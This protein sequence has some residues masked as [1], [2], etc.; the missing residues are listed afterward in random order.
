M[1]NG[2]VVGI[3]GN[4]NFIEYAINHNHDRPFSEKRSFQVADVH[5][6]PYEDETFD[7]VFCGNVLQLVDDPA[8]PLQEFIR[9]TKIGGRVADKS[10]D[11]SALIFQPVD[12]ILLHRVLEAAARYLIKD[13]DLL[14]HDNYLGRK[15]RG[16][17]RKFGLV[18]LETKAYA[19]QKYFPLSDS[20]KSYITSNARWYL[21]MAKP[22]LTEEEITAWAG[23][24]NPASDRYILDDEAFYYCM[25]EIMSIGKRQ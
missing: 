14:M 16:V 2:E 8:K 19:L 4:E 25:V 6:L 1:P 5:M 21:E 9:V 12:T 20:E 3:D 24:F 23:Y 7:L 11:G 10:F 17:F 13:T 22:Y 18:D 15:M